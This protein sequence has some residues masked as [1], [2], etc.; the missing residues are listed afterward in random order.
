[1]PATGPQDVVI[2]TGAAGG[3]GQALVRAYAQAGCAVLGVDRSAAPEDL[4][5]R[6]WLQ[7][8]LARSVADADYAAGVFHTVRA[9]L[10]G[11]PLRAL[12]HNAATQ[13]LGGTTELSLADWQ[14]TLQVNLLAPFLWTQALLP[15]LEA[16]P[17][18]VL[19]ISSIHARLT[20]PG[21]VAYATSKA[22]LSGLTRAMAVDLGGRVRVNA[23]EPAAIATPMLEAGFAG[24]PD[25]RC[26]LDHC[27]PQGRIGQPQEVA[28]AALALTLGEARFL[29]G[30]CL[31]LDG[32]IGVRLHDPA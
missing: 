5:A 7:V 9:L 10:A 6:H 8:D 4:P 25:A 29:H 17:G 32:G 28:A 19:H 22:A 23:L 3:I 31:A 24:D 21:F 12:V 27:H 30:A 1:M 20:K 15:E 11:R 2:I 14:L 26:T 13:V 16:A 18:S